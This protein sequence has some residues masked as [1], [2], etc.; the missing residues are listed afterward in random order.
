[1][2]LEKEI[3]EFQKSIKEFRDRFEATEKGLFTKAEFKEFTDKITPRID[4]LETVINRPPLAAPEEKGDEKAKEG[5]AEYNKAFY[6][7]MR[8]GVLTLDAKAAKYDM[9]RKALVEDAV[10]QILVTEEVESEIWRLMPTLNVLRPLCG[11]RTVSKDRIR[12]RGISEVTVGWGK[13]ELGGAPPES[14]L[15]PVDT[16]QYV[17][18]L[19]GLTKVGKDELMD[20][21]VNIEP[22]IADSFARAMADA[23]ELA[24]IRGLGHALEQPVGMVTAASGI[25]HH[26]TDVINVAD[27]EDFIQLTYE[28]APQYRAN[29]AFLVN[30]ATEMMLR[31]LRDAALGTF[32]WQPSVQA[33]KPN[34]FL[35]FPMYTCNHLYTLANVDSPIAVFGDFKRGYRIIDR[36]GISIQRLI[37]VYHAAGLIGFHASKRVGGSAFDPNALVIMDEHA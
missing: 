16:Y 18:D 30:S 15:V 24:F 4:S 1:M 21:D 29:G 12:L 26:D 6:N 20:S 9:E 2:E 14:T 17:E 37:E 32:S 25:A 3:T 22:I 28:I 11:V 5:K 36:I 35:G 33:G 19:E 8:T 27:I 23:E 34:S 10:G 31:L 7:Y 13:L